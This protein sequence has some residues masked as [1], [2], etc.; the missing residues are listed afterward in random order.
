M[1]LEMEIIENKENAKCMMWQRYKEIEYGFKFGDAIV[2]RHSADAEG[3]VI[4]RIK[5]SKI[6]IQ[7]YVTKEGEIRIFSDYAEW[8]LQPEDELRPW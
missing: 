5:T 7:I 2:E 4:I 6:W 1:S 3:G 8:I